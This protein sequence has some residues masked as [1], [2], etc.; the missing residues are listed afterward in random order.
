MGLGIF[1]L[2]VVGIVGAFGLAIIIHGAYMYFNPNKYSLTRERKRELRL[3][4]VRNVPNREIYDTL[5]VS[6]NDDNHVSGVIF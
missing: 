5:I 3:L 2:L 4:Q 1:G 6:I